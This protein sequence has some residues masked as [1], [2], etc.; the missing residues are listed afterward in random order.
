MFFMRDLLLR[1]FLGFGEE[2]VCH[3][4]TFR[5]SIPLLDTNLITSNQFPKKYPKIGIVLEAAQQV[6]DGGQ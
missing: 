6:F 4:L 3:S 1:A 2:G 5:F